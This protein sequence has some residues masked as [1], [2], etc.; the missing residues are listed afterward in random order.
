MFEEDE[1]VEEEL[2]LSDKINA[3]II[4]YTTTFAVPVGDSPYPISNIG[5]FR[6]A[7]RAVD[8]VEA[9]G[10]EIDKQRREGALDRG[11]AKA[12]LSPVAYAE[13]MVSK[14]TEASDAKADIIYSII[15]SMIHEHAELVS[16]TASSPHG[17]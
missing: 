3:A 15:R 6:V 7:W 8:G 10:E 12:D 4:E 14:M 17:L 2:T 5:T 11:A 13:N 1:E 16:G 9:A